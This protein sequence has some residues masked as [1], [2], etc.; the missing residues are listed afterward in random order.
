M[1]TQ[2]Y[3][4]TYNLWLRFSSSSGFPILNGSQILYSVWSQINSNANVFSQKIF[5]WD[6]DQILASNLKCQQLQFKGSDWWYHPTPPPDEEN[7][8]DDADAA[9]ESGESLVVQCGK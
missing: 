5:E 6:M 8:S 2:N 9:D 1:V 7:S 4:R 3:G